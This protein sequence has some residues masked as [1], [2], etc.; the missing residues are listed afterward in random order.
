[1]VDPAQTSPDPQP[2]DPTQ[3][4]VIGAS[5]LGAGHRERDEPC[6][7]HHLLSWLGEG[8]RQALVLAVAD[9]A[10]SARHAEQGSRLAVAGLRDAVGELLARERLPS[11]IEDLDTWRWALLRVRLGLQ[12]H[13]ME[14][15][16]ELRD[17]ACTLLAVVIDRAGAVCLQL[18]DG[19][20]LYGKQHE[21]LPVFRPTRGEF[22]NETVFVVSPGAIDHH[23]QIARLS[24]VPERLVLMS[25]GLENVAI[26]QQTGK[27]YER[28]FDPL[29]ERL[30]QRPPGLDSELSDE[31][32]AWMDRPRINR[33][34]DDD[35]TLILALAMDTEVAMPATAETAEVAPLDPVTD[36]GTGEEHPAPSGAALATAP[37]DAPA[38]AAPPGDTPSASDPDPDDERGDHPAG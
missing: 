24:R 37:A 29:F 30:A 35:K 3:W 10:G 32:A 33:H 19:F 8:D 7:D 26:V 36:P 27:G 1:M 22:A 25:D 5:T 9:G 12:E 38:E 13:A 2:R 18:G 21:Y 15:R 4:R 14:H 34:T 23:L 17:L 28:L 20:I 16:L 6:Q 11:Q 31:L